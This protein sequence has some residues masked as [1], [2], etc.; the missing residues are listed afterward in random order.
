M[1]MSIDLPEG[2]G[3]DL[4]V[5]HLA[6]SRRLM[7]S[8]R[9][10]MDAL[11]FHRPAEEMR[12]ETAAT[13]PDWWTYPDECHAGHPCRPGLIIVSWSPF[14]CPGAMTEPGRGHRVVR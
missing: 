2:E 5:K 6:E 13:R 14:K 7:T 3:R 1:T 9:E 10:K 12:F 11:F 8:Q 4:A